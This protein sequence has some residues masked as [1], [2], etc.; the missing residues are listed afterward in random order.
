VRRNPPSIFLM[1][2]EMAVPL[3]GAIFLDTN[4]IAGMIVMVIAHEATGFWEVRYAVTAHEVALIDPHVHSFLEMIRLMAIVCVVS[5]HWRQFLALFGQGDE[6]ARPLCHRLA[7][8]QAAGRLRRHSP[9]DD[10]A[11]R[12]ASLRRKVPSWPTRQWRPAGTVGGTAARRRS[13]R[14]RE[15]ALGPRKHC[16]IAAR[17]RA[18]ECPLASFSVMS[19]QAPARRAPTGDALPLSTHGQRT[20]SPVILTTRSPGPG[21]I[22]VAFVVDRAESGICTTREASANQHDKHELL[23]TASLI[24][25]AHTARRVHVVP[26]SLPQLDGA[27]RAPAFRCGRREAPGSP[28]MT[29]PQHSSETGERS[30]VQTGSG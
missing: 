8:R 12:G 27:P 25:D 3:L 1:F 18:P 29:F 6:P 7:S 28:S 11:A 5:F 21:R 19:T 23:H 16:L 2:A 30:G 9:A 4:A 14:A 26:F 15:P 24:C 20:S 17:S 22:N 13:S 10:P